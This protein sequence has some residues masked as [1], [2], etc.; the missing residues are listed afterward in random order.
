MSIKAYLAA[1]ILAC[2]AGGYA[3][4]AVLSIQI[5]NIRKLN[6]Q[7][8]S[9]L[10]WEK[11][12][13]RTSENTAQFLISADLILGSGN[14]YLLDGSVKKGKLLL[15]AFT[16]LL[17]EDSSLSDSPLIGAS[18]ELIKESNSLLTKVS[19][20]PDDSKFN[21][22]LSEMLIEHDEIAS[23]LQLNLQ[24]ITQQTRISLQAAKINL[25]KK[26]Q[27][28]I[29]F[30][31][32]AR[33]AFFLL[34]S[35]LWYW[36]SKQISRPLRHLKESTA[37]AVTGSDFESTT[38]G[39]TEII[40]L[41]RHLEEITT[42][43][44]HQASH[45]LLTGLYNRRAFERILK[46]TLEDRETGNNRNVVICF[47]DL[48]YFKTINDSC[49]HAEGDKLL[50]SVARVLADSI[51]TSDVVSRIGG[52]EFAIILYGCT[53]DRAMKVCEE[54]RSDICDI[55][56]HC[57]SK[58]FNIGASIGVAEVGH[59]VKTITDILH[60]ADI[61]CSTAKESGR[62]R[63]HAF[64]FSENHNKMKSKQLISIDEIK[65]A[66]KYNRFVLFGQRIISLDTAA[67][68]YGRME[69]LLRMQ[70]AG[71]KL[72]QPDTFLPAAERYRILNQIDQW[73]INRAI[74]WFTESGSDIDMMETININLSVQ[75]LSDHNIKRFIID[76]LESSNFPADKLCFEVDEQSAISHFND[77]IKLMS[78]LRA[79]G[80][81]FTLDHF[82]SGHSSYAK[83]RLIPSEQIKI[84][85]QLIREMINNPVDYATVKSICEISK[86]LRQTTVALHVDNTQ[87]AESL[88]VLNVD[89]AQG[90]LYSEPEALQ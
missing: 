26:E 82:G 18:S 77:T 56:H 60:A 52:D 76:K 8:N 12:L 34:I 62:N 88:K 43:L 81:R 85:G 74:D 29:L 55:K 90:Y 58:K 16:H 22:R 17:N 53:I 51:R 45:D 86:A 19:Q 20:L 65:D 1:L 28:V 73:V 70:G 87:T 7:F 5:D 63:V 44:F 4:E 57:D 2:L 27:Q 47:I 75:S 41:S 14:T 31:D 32:M 66:I 69:I 78:D 39:P 10:L 40:D 24:E 46:C 21:D 42:S 83:L 33:V 84:E 6:N 38:S 3:L 71:N 79:Y 59:H 72:V 80:C 25:E 37:K 15:T 48:D 13:K 50:I 89:F 61:A 23:R 11:D 36:A 30:R 9:D 35:F 64:D 49:G 68:R 67:E 54:I